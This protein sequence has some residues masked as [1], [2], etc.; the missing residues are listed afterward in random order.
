MKKLTLP[1]LATTAALLLSA[2]SVISGLIPDQKV[3]VLGGQ[4]ELVLPETALLTEEPKTPEVFSGVTNSSLKTAATGTYIPVLFTRGVDDL[5][6]SLA[7]TPKS[8]TQELSLRKLVF[9]GGSASTD[10]PAEISLELQNLG[11]Y[12]WDGHAGID[13]ATPAEYYANSAPIKNSAIASV[14]KGLWFETQTD[15]AVLK[16]TKDA[17]QCSVDSCAYT[18]NADESGIT[19]FGINESSIEQMLNILSP[20]DT[21]E[22]KNTVAV[23]G[24]YKIATDLDYSLKVGLTFNT[25]DAII[26]FKE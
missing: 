14:I 8:L 26:S 4:E 23:V 7:I 19:Q 5:T 13:V 21:D 17:T 25:P 10:F 1:L 2:C 11:L 18:L 24:S 3:E 20:A 12:L 22:P 16:Y 15:Q 6:E 9:T